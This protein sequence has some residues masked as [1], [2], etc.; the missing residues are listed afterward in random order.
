MRKECRTALTVI[1]A[2]SAQD[3]L[4]TSA[5]HLTNAKEKPLRDRAF[6]G[7]GKRYAVGK[8][9]VVDHRPEARKLCRIALII[10]IGAVQLQYVVL[11]VGDDFVLVGFKETEWEGLI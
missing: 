5:A 3:R 2:L 4:V 1:K 10:R 6:D 11:L 8:D 7:K 9:G